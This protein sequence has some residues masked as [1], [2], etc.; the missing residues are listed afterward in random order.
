MSESPTMNAA[1]LYG[2]GEPLSVV[3]I[4]LPVCVEAEVLVRVGATGICGSDIQIAVEGITP[5][6]YQP[7]VL[8]HEIASTVA[9]VGADARGWAR[10]DR[11]SVCAV[12][13][14]GRA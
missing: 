1:R 8:V 11:V 12:V 3:R 5:T 7:I 6:P 2:P 13:G 9:E 10:G 14:D 4:P